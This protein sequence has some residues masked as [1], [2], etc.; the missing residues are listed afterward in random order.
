M[1]VVFCT[2]IWHEVGWSFHCSK[3]GDGEASGGSA[4]TLGEA[5]Q[6][7]WAGQFAR[8]SLRWWTDRLECSFGS[9]MDCL[10]IGRSS[11][12]GRSREPTALQAS[13][14]LE[15]DE[16]GQEYRTESRCEARPAG[17]ISSGIAQL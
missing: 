16:L 8:A 10:P 1:E 17:R 12:R 6:H 2:E 3:S 11:T 5:T 7:S 14:R 4:N 13:E 15:D 9:N